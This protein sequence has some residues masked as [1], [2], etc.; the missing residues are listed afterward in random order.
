MKIDHAFFGTTL[1]WC[2]APK[3]R[4]RE[5]I[6]HAA[7]GGDPCTKCGQPARFH[8]TAKSAEHRRQR[9]RT[10][11]K[12]RVIIGVDGEGHDLP[13]GR[14]I[15][16]LLCAVDETGKV[17]GEAENPNGLSA[18]ECIDM[19]L[20]LPQHALKFIFM[21][22]YD[23]TKMIEDLELTD[24]VYIMHPESRR[25]KTC[26]L[27]RKRWGL[28]DVKCPSCNHDQSRSVQK[29]RRVIRDRH[30]NELN[31]GFDWFNGS[32]T[33]QRGKRRA[34]VWD[35]FKFFQCSFVKAIKQWK[36]GTDEQ[37]ARIEDMKSKRGAFAVE[38]PA[39][40]RRYCR[41]ECWL[42]AKMMRELLTACEAA[43][44][45]LRQYHGAGSIAS[46]LLKMHE[47][48]KHLGPPLESMHKGLQH[49]VMS[50]YF[51]GRFENSI[52][53]YALKPVHNRDIF[54]AYPYAIA[55]LP[56][57]ACGKWRKAKRVKKSMSGHD[58]LLAECR[59][60]T[61]AVVHFKV[62]SKTQ[63][64]RT[65]IPWAP[66]P[67]RLEGGS[68]TF[69]TGFE[70]WA[71][72]PEL[73]AALKGWPD[74]IQVSEAWVYETT[75]DH[76]PFHWVPA[77]YRQRMEWG[78]DGKGIV[79]KLGLNA[80]AGKTMQNQGDPPPYK[81][82]IYG[83]MITGT[84]RSQSLEAIISAQD[85]WNVL[86]I[87][88]DGVFAT[89]FLPLPDAKDTGTNDLEKPLG[90]WGKELHEDGV[91]FVKPGMY[92]D[93]AK[94]L[95][96]DHDFKGKGNYCEKCE[97]S[98]QNHRS[99]MR[100]RGI[101]RTELNKNTRRIAESFERWDRKSE[102]KLRV[103]SR[104][105]YGARSSVLM[106]SRCL[107]CHTSW[108]GWPEKGCPKCGLLGIGEAKLMNL[109]DKKTPAYGRWYP[110]EII[111]EF[112]SLPKREFIQKDGSFGRMRIRDMG[113]IA[114]LAYNPG[115]TTPQGEA[116]K[117]ATEEALEEP[118]WNDYDDATE[119][120]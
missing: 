51:G 17:V 106:Y 98:K 23:W 18:R 35:C 27:C 40:I 69:P 4:H 45:K 32:F 64:E 77:A 99:V 87:A 39:D 115:T 68:I 26:K 109:P 73:E 83:G 13:D 66:L 96:Q 107:D 56:C 97:E 79:M 57:L 110:R 88:T 37:W 101:G 61:L 74:L 53:G 58:E 105:F 50:A 82:W 9:D 104:R 2:G 114:S 10:H 49:A 63:D 3:S 15:Y 86:A 25:M 62:K 120:V 30:G 8:I 94:N 72:M 54:S 95:V 21:G 59:A 6:Y 84:T 60:A 24:I 41:E 19:L 103:M 5:R 89:E 117:L 47:V 34:K 81:S 46:A 119:A 118:D 102:L 28:R 55:Q 48:K 7:E 111:I 112:A 12:E 93:Q 1:C 16:T 67:C 76:K 29:L 33:V 91:F 52:V 44:I 100:A 42:L 11:T 38:D 22:S 70:G 78:K 65:D 108:P 116:S 43:G 90:N 75:C 85:R 113:G 80:C 92:F 36:I 31:T 14:H 20:G 71:W